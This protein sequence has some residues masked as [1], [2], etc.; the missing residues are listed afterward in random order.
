MLVAFSA[1]L[2]FAFITLEPIIKKVIDTVG[3]VLYLNWNS[4]LKIVWDIDYIQNETF[5]MGHPLEIVGLSV[6]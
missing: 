3:I 6:L 2:T 4:G 5:S 1:F